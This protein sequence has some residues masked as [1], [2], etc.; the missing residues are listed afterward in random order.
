MS[1]KAASASESKSA[2][3]AGMVESMNRLKLSPQTRSILEYWMS[4]H[5]ADETLPFNGKRLELAGR[6]GNQQGRP[7]SRP[8]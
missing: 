4:P 5:G 6:S 3:A 8:Y 7:T 2:L 1:P